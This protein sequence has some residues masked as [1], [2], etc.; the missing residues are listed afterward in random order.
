MAIDRMDWHYESVEECNLPE[1][2]AGTHIGMFL[3]WAINRNFLG[4]FH[5]DE[6]GSLEYI[7]KVKNRVCTGVEF[8]IDMCDEKFWDEDLNEE[9]YEFVKDYYE[10]DESEFANRYGSYFEDYETVFKDYE[11]LYHVENSW[12]NY[13][14]LAP[15]LDKRYKEW[16]DYKNA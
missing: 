12:E 7:D 5:T 8:L 9:V 3:A 13:D 2:N 14:K 1:N 15:I 6:E 10:D 4:E 11:T 16:L